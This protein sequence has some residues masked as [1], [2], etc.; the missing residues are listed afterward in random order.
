M[1]CTLTT[2]FLTR[3]AGSSMTLL[4]FGASAINRGDGR[5]V[6]LSVELV[7]FNEK[8]ELAFAISA[9]PPMGTV[10]TGQLE[11][12]AGG[13]YLPG[14]IKTVPAIKVC[15]RV[16][17]GI[18]VVSGRLLWARLE[19]AMLFSLP[20]R[21]RAHSDLSSSSAPFAWTSIKTF[22]SFGSPLAAAMRLSFS[23]M[24]SR[25]ARETQPRLLGLSQHSASPG[26]DLDQEAARRLEDVRFPTGPYEQS[27]QGS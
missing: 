8:N 23:R 17:T 4:K 27:P 13:V 10:R 1:I 20:S 11:D 26:R 12:V 6:Y 22:A 7:G 3:G 5:N 15:I 25:A 16:A 18:V 14:P 24:R 21:A 19:L 9:S 2:F